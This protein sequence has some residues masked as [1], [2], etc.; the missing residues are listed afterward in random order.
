M[1]G[2]PLGRPHDTAVLSFETQITTSKFGSF[3]EMLNQLL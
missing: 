2:P 1:E 3:D